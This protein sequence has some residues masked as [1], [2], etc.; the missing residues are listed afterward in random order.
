[1]QQ[2]A[3]NSADSL[4]AGKTLSWNGIVSKVN[5]GTGKTS[6]VLEL[7]N[8]KQVSG[9]WE[10]PKSAIVSQAEERPFP[11]FGLNDPPGVWVMLP[12]SGSDAIINL[13]D[14]KHVTFRGIIA[15]SNMRNSGIVLISGYGGSF[16]GRHCV[17]L[18]VEC[19]EINL[20]KK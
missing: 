11:F 4:F 19:V 17:S 8:E 18:F 5:S 2:K 3:Y 16:S 1:D 7:T 15:K 10:F 13:T 12:A 9:N 6:V 14:G 20:I